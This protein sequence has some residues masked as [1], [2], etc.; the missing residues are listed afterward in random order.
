MLEMCG[1]AGPARE[2]AEENVIPASMASCAGGW[3]EYRCRVLGP[4]ETSR[5]GPETGEVRRTL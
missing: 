4:S 1:S 2:M 5:G 3:C